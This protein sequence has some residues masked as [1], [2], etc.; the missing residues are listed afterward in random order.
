[1]KKRIISTIL[2]ICS[3]FSLLMMTSCGKVDT[4]TMV[5]DA[6]AKTSALDA[7]NED[8][9]DNGRLLHGYSHEG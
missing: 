3:V 7:G 6:M 1:M 8:Q 2:A 5:D 9:H 4:Y